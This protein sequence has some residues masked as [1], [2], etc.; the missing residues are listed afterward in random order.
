[1]AL[2]LAGKITIKKKYLSK[3]SNLKINSE[4]NFFALCKKKINQKI[5]IDLNYYSLIDIRKIK[6]ISSKVGI[7]ADLIKNEVIIYEKNKI[8]KIK[9]N[10]KFDTYES[11]VK[12]FLFNNGRNCASYEDGLM[13]NKFIEKVKNK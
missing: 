4:D 10:Y 8:R 11:L 2:K 13:V 6:F 12:D 9:F 1:M 3:L 7:I 5:T